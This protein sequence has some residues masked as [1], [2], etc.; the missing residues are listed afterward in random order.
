MLTWFKGN[1][2]G[3]N[4]IQIQMIYRKISI[5]QYLKIVLVRNH[6]IARLGVLV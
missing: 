2:R 4:E 5:T 3:G 1:E 6:E